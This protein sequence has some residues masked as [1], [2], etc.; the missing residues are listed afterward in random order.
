MSRASRRPVVLLLWLLLALLPLR[1][2]AQGTMGLAATATHAQ[3][4]P[5][6]GEMAEHPPGHADSDGASKSACSHCDLCHAAAAPNDLQ[7]PPSAALPDTAPAAMST[8]AP[9]ATAADSLFRPP[10]P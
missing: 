1:G 2:W 6:H 5:C 4:L 10:R 3:A 7:A 9:A 8:Q